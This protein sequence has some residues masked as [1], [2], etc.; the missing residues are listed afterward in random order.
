MT[1]TAEHPDLIQQLDAEY[2]AKQ[3]TYVSANTQARWRLIAVGVL[4]LGAVRAFGM[5]AVPWAFLLGFL[6]ASA[7]ANLA[8]VWLVRRTAFRPAYVTLTLA[9]G[10]AMISAVV[11]ALDR[12]GYLLYGAYLIAPLQAAFYLGRRTA[13]TS[14]GINLTGF[15][16]VAGLRAPAHQWGWSVFLQAALVVAFTAFALIPMLTDITRRLRRTRQLL[17]QVERGDL[18]V[19][20]HDPADDE[21]GHLS[22]SVDQTTAAVAQ[23]IREVQLQ[24]RDLLP[25]ARRL[26]VAAGDLEQFAR[27]VTDATA[28]V[29]EGTVRQRRSI[30][31]GRE[32]SEAAAG[33]ATALHRRFREAT[34]Q[35]QATAAE[36]QRHGEE[37]RQAS[38]L[39]ESLVGHIDRAGGAAATL[40]QSSR[41]VGKLM[42]G[43]TRIASQTELLALNA[44]IEAARAGQF[45]AGF[46]V[47]ADEVRKLAEQSSRAAE[48]IRGRMRLTQEQISSVAEA[49]RQGREAA[50]NAGVVSGA[51]GKALDAIF[52]AVSDTTRLASAF[53]TDVENQTH[54]IDSVVRRIGDL[55]DIGEEAAAVAERSSSATEQQLV[56]LGE[57]TQASERLSAAATRLM[58]STE[59]FRVDGTASSP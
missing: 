39:L 22:D 14:V 55:A 49:L 20:L 8:M 12:T 5:V 1:G 46:R 32:A 7:A 44:A 23:A 59:R 3:R 38:Q 15:A 48:Q 11:Y 31:A 47:V 29:V 56:A 10:G 16:I 26:S 30:A 51:A 35:A 58:R 36:A 37:I 25:L 9:L 45:G 53:A 2:R 41:E 4:L 18:V 43:I 27:Q 21:L 52:G 50:Q 33:I 34:Q 28:H 40:E 54:Q 24:A 6:V 19:R 13:W 42:D 57:L 17:A